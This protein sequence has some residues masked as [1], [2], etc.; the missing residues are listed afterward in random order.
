LEKDDLM[1]KALNKVDIYFP[2][3]ISQIFDRTA[4]NSNALVDDFF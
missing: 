1:V 2:S 4:M 3:S